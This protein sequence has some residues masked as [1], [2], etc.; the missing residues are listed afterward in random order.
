MTVAPKF[1]GTLDQKI[2]TKGRVSV[3]A[4]LRKVAEQCDPDFVPPPSRDAKG[5]PASILIVFEPD[6]MKCLECYSVNGMAQ[7]DAMID[8]LDIGSAEREALEFRYHANVTLTEIDGDGRIVI[9][10]AHRTK[11][12]FD[13][14]IRFIGFGDR[15][16]IWTPAAF[17]ASRTT[18]TSALVSRYGADLN[19]RSL[20]QAKRVE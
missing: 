20:L 16:E 5:S 10:L 12:G 18:P 14:E 13:G 7:I 1:K 15:F 2:D 9:P 19:L 11:L 4:A 3:P 8:Q 17:A 6:T